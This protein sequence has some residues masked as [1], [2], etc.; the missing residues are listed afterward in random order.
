MDPVFRIPNSPGTPLFPVSPDRVNRQQLPLSPSRQSD[1][2]FLQDDP[3]RSYHSR[4]SSDVQGKVAQFNNLSK[5]ASQRRKENEAALKRAMVGREEAESETRRL[6]EENRLLMKE[7][8]DGNTRE[9][10]VGERVEAVMEEMQRLKENQAHSQ[11]LYEKEVRR[12]RKEAFKSSSALVKLQE[13]LKTTRNKYTLVREDVEI[14]RR[15]VENREQEAFA[16]KYELV[17]IQEELEEA[18]QRLKITEE[19]RDALKTSLK[20]EEVARVAAEGKIP[21]PSSSGSDEFSSPRKSRRESGKEN[22]DPFV[23]EDAT[24]AVQGEDDLSQLKVE[25]EREKRWRLRAVELIDFMKAECQ[26]SRC[27][28]R[29]AARQGNTCIH[30][31]GEAI[32]ET[33]VESHYAK[34]HALLDILSTPKQSS[35]K[36]AP[37][38]GYQ[39]E[40]DA[41]SE[42]LIEFSPTTGTFRTLHFPVRDTPS[43]LPTPSRLFSDEPALL[44]PPMNAIL[45]SQSPSLLSIGEATSKPATSQSPDLLPAGADGD[46]DKDAGNH[47]TNQSPPPSIPSTPQNPTQRLPFRPQTAATT[48]RIISNTITT[49]IPL[50]DPATPAGKIPF[51]PT[52]N[53]LPYSPA[54]TMTREEALEQ[55]RQRR[56]RARSIAAGNGT[57]RK[58]MEVR[59]DISAPTVGSARRGRAL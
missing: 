36:V 13:E 17:G 22:M 21:L 31:D 28:C 57:P 32:L 8:E 58:A 10:R 11:T 14:Q 41:D 34:S 9:R 5:E 19:E 43:E 44:V 27:S 39:E 3:F 51:T 6:K 35:P 54:S 18:K 59:R 12:A 7:L 55:I 26:F 1:I 30:G 24:E 45:L 47:D 53:M 48:S 33:A 15:K 2:F 49:T 52:A 46:S 16:A 25:L 29:I 42:P 23:F 37:S 38:T 40:D 50:V 20:E 56:G 4:N